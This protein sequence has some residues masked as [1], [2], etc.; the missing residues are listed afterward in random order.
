MNFDDRQ[1]GHPFGDDYRGHHNPTPQMQRAVRRQVGDLNRRL[2]DQSQRHRLIREMQRRCDGNHLLVRMSE[3]RRDPAFSFLW[4]TG[5]V[6]LHADW[7]DRDEIR[8]YL[9]GSGLV[10]V[11]P[12]CA[13]LADRVV[14]VVRKESADRHADGRGHDTTPPK[15]PDELARGLRDLGAGAAPNYVVPLAPVGKGLD[16]PEPGTSPGDY[17]TYPVPHGSGSVPIG[18]IDTGITPENRAD[19]WLDNVPRGIDIDPLDVLPGGGDGRLDLQAGHGTF[20]AGA[21]QQVAPGADIRVYKAMDSDGRAT[22]MQVACAMLRAVSDGC[23]ILNLSFGCQ[24]DDD[25]E[26]VAMAAAMDVIPSDV[27]I[28]AAAGNYGDT[29]L[30]WPAAFPRVTSVAALTADLAPTTWSSRGT[31]VTMSTVGEGIS[32]TYVPGQESP[33][34]DPTP[35]TFG[36]SAWAVWSG[37]SFAAP[38]VAGAVARMC[39]G[40]PAMTPAQAVQALAQ[41]GVPVPEFGQAVAILPGL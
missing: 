36:A 30:V 18:V 11:P 1:P 7:Y 15:T 27:V 25:V 16:G 39:M 3:R 20:V 4:A 10:R 35:D 21:V 14:R 19:G 9:D 34:I 23:R 37:T 12:D 38:Q 13:A 31:W 22:D 28:I 40:D 29:A 6:L 32:S 24:T 26:P 17:A 5:E 41:A 2:T 8:R 33:I